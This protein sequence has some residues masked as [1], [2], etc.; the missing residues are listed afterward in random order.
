M[1]RIFYVSTARPRPGKGSEAA[2]WWKET[3]KP[4]FESIPGVKSL[5][6]FAGQFG[7]SGEYG[8]EFWYELENYAVMDLWDKDVAA[9]PQKYG[10]IFQEFNEL[11]DSGP[12]RVMGDWP[13]S[14]LTD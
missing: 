6:T 5:Q 14:R 11:F 12:S 1:Y 4:F 13:E 8:I 2:N 3:G 10:S 7:L 9:N